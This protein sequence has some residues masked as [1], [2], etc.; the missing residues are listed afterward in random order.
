MIK[1][2]F[3]LHNISSQSGKYDSSCNIIEKFGWGVLFHGQDGVIVL[4]RRIQ[5]MPVDSWR[6]VSCRPI[7]DRVGTFR[8]DLVADC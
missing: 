1:L 6:Q 3:I 5:G 2:R 4:D 7:F 8:L